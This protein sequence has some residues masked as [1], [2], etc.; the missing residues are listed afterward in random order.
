MENIC[1]K[2]AFYNPEKEYDCEMSEDLPVVC[3]V[4]MKK[5]REEIREVKK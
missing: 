5:K 4:K 3:S 1:L 2:C